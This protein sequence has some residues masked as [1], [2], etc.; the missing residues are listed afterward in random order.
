MLKCKLFVGLRETAVW[1][2]CLVTV[3]HAAVF[4]RAASILKCT[5][6]SF[7]PIELDERVTLVTFGR[8]CIKSNFCLRFIFVNFHIKKIR[9]PVEQDKHSILGPVRSSSQI[10]TLH[11]SDVLALSMWVQRTFK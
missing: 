6:F 11:R 3:S 10:C 8:S 5:R 2:L 4:P 7:V 9:K 1:D